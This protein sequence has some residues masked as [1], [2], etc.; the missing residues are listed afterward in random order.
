MMLLDSNQS[1]QRDFPEKTRQTAAQCRHYAMC[2][3]DFLGTGICASGMEKHFVSYFPQG[4]MDIYDALA[5]DLV[6]ITQG[7]VDI[8]DSCDLCGICDRQCHFVTGMRPVQVMKALKKHV[9]DWLA[10][11]NSP[12]PAQSDPDLDALRTIVGQEWVSNDPAI[13]VTYANDP[14]PLAGMRMPRFVAL[15][16]NQSEVT[17]LVRFANEREIPY[18]VRG[19]G[20]SVFGFVFSDGLVMDMHRMKGIEID[21]ENW[22]A[23]VEPGVT[24]FELQQEAVKHGFR[25]NTAE[26]A[27]TVC[28]NIVCTGLFSTWANAYGVNADTFVD[29]EFVDNNGKLFRL[30]DPASPNAFCYEHRLTPSPGICTRA[31]VRLHPV[32]DDEEGLLVPFADFKEAVDFAR[33]LSRRRIGL[34]IGV[35]GGHYL[36]TFMSPSAELAD[37]VR[38]SLTEAIGLKYAVFVIGDGFACRTVREMRDSVIDAELFRMFMLGLPNMADDEWVELIAGMDGDH[39]PYEILLRSEMRPV[40]DAVLRPAPE[41]AARAVDEDLQSFYAKLYTRPEMTDMVWLNMFR[42]LSSRMSRHKHMFAFLVYVPMDRADVIEEICAE[43]KRIADSHG[44]D[45]DYGFLTPLDLG[46]R[47]ILEYDYYIDHQDP[48]EAEKIRAAMVEFE[49]YLDNLSVGTKGVK[50]L[51]YIFSQG[52]ARKDAFLYT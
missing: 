36:S 47:G 7:L 26:P 41:T 25:V 5:R 23:L 1:I 14:F 8:A 21:A 29:M 19:N 18:V 51:K 6:P 44:I 12:V 3:I 37:R 22:T 27:A 38:H 15:P 52:C 11:G 32:T 40:L 16:R 33:D 20:G 2:K 10:L 34:A 4:R 48:E 50:W 30:N 49:P 17:A 31:H 35:L 24:S 42:I 13:L 45:N 9:R 28:G 43:L 39:A 46:K